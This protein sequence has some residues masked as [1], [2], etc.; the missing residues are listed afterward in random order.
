MKADLMIKNA[1]IFTSA[2]DKKE[3][4]A[5]A[6]KAGKF[7]YVGDED[8]L[9]GFDGEITDLGGSFIM[10]SIIDS[11]VHVTLSVALEY[12][13]MGIPIE[14]NNKKEA[15]CNI[16]EAIKKDPGA[17]QYRFMIERK[18]LQ[19]EDITKEDLDMICPDNELL[20]FEEEG[21]SIW[22]NSSLLSKFH[23]TDD[24][25]DPKPG[26][27]YY[28]R[29]DGHIT[30]NIFESAIMPFILDGTEDITDEQIDR[31]LERWIDNSVKNGVTCVFD[32]GIPSGNEF[33]ERVYK[34]LR[35]MDRQGKLPIYIDGCYLIWQPD[36]AKEGIEQLKRFNGEFQTEHLK[37]HTLKVF[38]DGT[39]KIGTAALVTPYKDTDKLGTT[40]FNTEQ[41]VEIL[42]EL[43]REGFDLHLHTVGEG[44]SRVV[45]DSVER[46]KG[47]L[48][49]SYRVK[50]TCAHLE[51]Q[52]D[53]DISR[54]VK[55]GVFA[56]FTPWWH[57][58]NT[59]DIPLDTWL[60]LL[61]EKRA[62]SMY[63]CKT[64]W[65]TGALVTWSSDEIYYSDFMSWNPY[66]GMEVGMTRH[67]TEKTKAD[68]WNRTTEAF[69][70]DSERMSIEEMLLGYTINGALQLGIENCKGSIEVGKDADFL[71][72]DKNLLTAV[73]E[74]FSHNLPRDVFIR[75]E[76][77]KGTSKKS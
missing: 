32:A 68:E 34:R 30:G 7:I 24:T 57:A 41:L 46:V 27:S 9:L 48:G 63:R 5:L 54:F 29:K 73:K 51:I 14:C 44:A 33:H 3:A 62:N 39:L 16:S 47:E 56:N 67:I 8:G 50:V 38:M 72:F 70:P 77:V 65:D 53:N 18:S 11:H 19:G 60:E 4:Y 28:V 25:P 22:V 52:D 31:A 20:I 2:G 36:K 49:D 59:A 6:V 10:P 23:I 58:G 1:K 75:G 42:K 21:H 37:V 43:N 40:Y 71:V 61:G 66:L 35:E 45:L 17:K 13:D 15:L 26:L 74:G 12:V 69:P 76:K 64:L 55:L